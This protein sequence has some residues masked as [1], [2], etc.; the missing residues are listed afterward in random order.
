VI[1]LDEAGAANQDR[2]RADW[3]PW[4]GPTLEFIDIPT[5]QTTAATDALLAIEAAASA[6][7]VVR[8][9]GADR[10]R[11]LLWVWAFVLLAVS[12]ALG[13]I[14]H[15]VRLDPPMSEL[16]WHPLYL[17]LGLVVGLIAVAV[18]ADL[19]RERASR[20][21]LPV[22]LGL[23]M[24]FFGVTLVVPGGFLVFVVYETVFMVFALG[25]YLR[26]ALKEH[27][28]GAGWMVTGIILTI[29]ASAIQ[30]TGRLSFTV[31]WPFDHNGIFHI[32][33]M[34][35]VGALVMGL[36][37]LLRQTVTKEGTT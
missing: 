3:S 19:W 16:I 23:G 5:E 17:G 28:P 29:V 6:W 31:I 32:V 2:G 22:F 4:E 25:G 12:A 8:L 34:L 33:Q 35:G 30:A 13:A 10:W 21:V 9:P 1:S 27:R 15:G 20:R 18:V 11:A 37:R 24:V 36:R 7:V 26:L 14:A